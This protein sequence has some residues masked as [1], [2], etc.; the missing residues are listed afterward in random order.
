MKHNVFYLSNLKTLDDLRNVVLKR[1]G[2]SFPEIDIVPFDFS[3]E[4]NK[5]IQN[6]KVVG[7]HQNFK[8]LYFCLDEKQKD[9]NQTL[10]SFLRKTQKQIIKEIPK[11]KRSSFL[12]VF[13]DRNGNYWNFVNANSADKRLKLRRFSITPE[14]KNKIRTTCEQLDLL[15]VVKGDTTQ[16]LINK[17]D[18]AFSVEAVSKRFYKE[19]R[20]KV[21][22]DLKKFL[23][24]QNKK[25]DLRNAHRFAHQLL[26]RLMFLYFMQKKGVFGGYKHFMFLFWNAYRDNYEGKDEF[27]ELWLKV[28]FFE[29]LNNDFHYRPYFNMENG[30]PNFNKIFQFET[31]Y[32]NGGLFKPN[33]LDRIGYTIPDSKFTRIFEFLESYNFTIQE[34][35]PFEQDLDINPQ[36]LGNIY[37]MLVNVSE[38]EDERHQAGIFYTPKVEIELMLR[39]SLVEFLHSKTKIG[40]EKLYL[41]I[42]HENGEEIVPKFEKGELKKLI[43]ELDSI[44]IVDPACGSGHY[45]VVAAQ[46]LWELKEE[47]YKQRGERVDKFEEKKRIIEKSIYGVD[48]KDWAVEIA[49]LRL[50]L[51]LIVDAEIDKFKT[52]EPLLPSLSFKLRVGDSLVQQIGGVFFTP[53]HVKGLPKSLISMLNTL[54]SWKKRY[55]RNDK[56]VNEGKIKHKEKLFFQAIIDEK[57]NRLK[58]NI[59]KLQS[60]Q[61]ENAHQLHFLSLH[62]RNQS[63]LPINQD[64]KRKI[65]KIKNQIKELEKQKKTIKN[66]SKNYTYWPIEFADIFAEKG[67]FDIVI[68]NPPYV[69]QELIADPTI[70]GEQS[71]EERRKYKRK[72]L[73]QIQHDWD[74]KEGKIVKIPKRAD[75]YV[76]FY[77]KGLKLLNPDGVMCFISSNSWLDVDYGKALQEILLKYV[78]II[79]VYDNQVKRSFKHADVNTIIALFKAPLKKEWEAN[80]KQHVVKFVNFKKPFEEVLYSDIFIEIEKINKRTTTDIFQVHPITQWELYQDGLETPKTKEKSG[81]K[82]FEAK[83]FGVYAG[84]K[85]GGKYLRA[86]DIYWKIL[87]KGKGKLVRLGDIA[88]IRRGFT[89]GANEFFYLEDVT[90]LIEE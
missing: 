35:T 1:W 78:P 14:N 4:I 52:S 73:E 47:L 24:Q 82:G 16:S 81:Q 13:S 67:G 60:S 15:K 30:Y 65:E 32:L 72:L 28:L 31:P 69:R 90:D 20:E 5:K 33:G 79:A 85:W 64:S 59:Q 70:E 36:M 50:W 26:N 2:F 3:S 29:A 88:E 55:F 40:K 45:L 43:Q 63:K 11:E 68:A 53:Q 54:K 56:V 41:F 83:E 42:F 61:I 77:L 57:I 6:K 27:Y 7:E 87:E 46:I 80:L 17:L 25:A 89:T 48:V 71:L 39:R 75:L 51:D 66:S 34:N 62:Q 58:Q 84:N 86:P 18:S 10:E 38:K 44:T 76:Y 8:I 12:F 74:D 22:D 21:F 9:K 23:Y 37:E 19:Y 49:K